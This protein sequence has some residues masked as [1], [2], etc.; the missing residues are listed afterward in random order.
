MAGCNGRCSEVK[1]DLEQTTYSLSLAQNTY[2]LCF[3]KDAFIPVEQTMGFSEDQTY[4][5]GETTEEADDFGF[6]GKERVQRD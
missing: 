6:I 3:R 5:F 1:L 2:G 4:G